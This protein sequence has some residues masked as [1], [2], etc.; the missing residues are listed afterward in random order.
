MADRNTRGFFAGLDGP[1]RRFAIAVRETLEQL[2]S[3]VDDAVAGTPDH[4]SLSGLS[5]NDH[6]QYA[7]VA[8][9]LSDL[10]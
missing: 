1:T 10:G 3:D 6:P 8:L 5:D 7:R 2:R 4:G 9:I